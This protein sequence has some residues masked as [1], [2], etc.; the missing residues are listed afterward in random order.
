MISLGLV[1]DTV[2]LEFIQKAGT[3]SNSLDNGRLSY[4][5]SVNVGRFHFAVKIHFQ[6]QRGG[7][8]NSSA[9]LAKRHM[10]LDLASHF[11]R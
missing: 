7:I 11:R 8:E 1:I 3:A 10:A 9:I 6:R 2:V 4:A 5:R